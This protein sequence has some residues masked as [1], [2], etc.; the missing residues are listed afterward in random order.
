[1]ATRAT[2]RILHVADPTLEKQYSCPIAF[3]DPF[4][5]FAITQKLFRCRYESFHKDQPELIAEITDLRDIVAAGQK[6]LL[7]DRG[8]SIEVRVVQDFSLMFT[9]AID[10]GR[11]SRL[12]AEEKLFAY[13]TEDQSRRRFLHVM[14]LQEDGVKEILGRMYHGYITTCEIEVS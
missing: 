4:L 13:F 1:M 2:I 14:Q 3:A 5:F 7:V 8:K 11:H 9:H 10:G 12:V 6:Y